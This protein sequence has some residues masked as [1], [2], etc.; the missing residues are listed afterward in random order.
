[1][2]TA[3]TL[4]SLEARLKMLACEIPPTPAPE[5]EPVNITPLGEESNIEI[6][7]EDGPWT[8]DFRL[9]SNIGD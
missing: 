9:Y 8:L 4:E 3:T 6:L 1:M 5:G 7:G 2:T